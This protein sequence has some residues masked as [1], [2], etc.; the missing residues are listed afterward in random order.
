MAPAHSGNDWVLLSTAVARMGELDPLYIKHTGAARNALDRA[1]FAGRMSLSGRPIGE[2]DRQ[3]I[4]GLISSE[5]RLD[6]IR[7]TIR[8]RGVRPP[9]EDTIL[10]LDVQIEWSGAAAY[11]RSQAG[12]AQGDISLLRAGAGPATRPKRRG[13]APGSVDRYG[14][15]DRALFPKIDRMVSEQQKSVHAAALILA[16]QGLVP[17]DGTKLSKAIRLARLY[18]KQRRKT[19]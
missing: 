1:I 9:Y 13:P 4:E 6:L 19:R 2:R 8:K 3:P 11:F 10:F 12:Q 5:H 14:K 16:E 17:G 18:R 7:D 15:A